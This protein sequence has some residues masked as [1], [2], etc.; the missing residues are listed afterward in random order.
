MSAAVVTAAFEHIEKARKVGV[1]V[2]VRIGQGVAHTCL[3]GEM[4]D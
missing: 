1:G 3:G 4:D 2:S